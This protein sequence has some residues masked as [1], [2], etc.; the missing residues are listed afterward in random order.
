MLTVDGRYYLYTFSKEEEFE[1]EV[2]KF[3][4]EIFGENTIYINTKKKSIA[5]ELGVSSIPDGFLL[6]LSNP[7][8]IAFYIVE[9]ELSSHDP[10]EIAKQILTFEI[11]YKSHESKGKVYD[12]LIEQIQNDK[13][14]LKIVNEALKKSTVYKDLSTLIYDVVFKQDHRYL[15]II[16]RV[17]ETLKEA[18]NILNV[19]FKIFEFVTFINQKGDKAYAFPNFRDEA[20]QPPE[21]SETWY[22]FCFDDVEEL[23]IDKETF[24]REKNI[25]FFQA[26]VYTKDKE[27]K[28]DG[29][30]FQGYRSR[31]DR[32][33]GGRKNK[34]E[35][36]WGTRRPVKLDNLRV[37]MWVYVVET[38]IDGDTGEKIKNPKL[39]VRGKLREVY[40]ERGKKRE[41]IFPSP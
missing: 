14:M 30:V 23:D 6:D 31:L 5:K 25:G 36:Q 38:N 2:V 20:A 26:F 17:T 41:R 15:I 29:I 35:F 10:K 19:D 28:I 13:E 40:K 1:R 8:D 22:Q 18:L 39:R 4:K 32:D 16:D 3:S 21:E 27:G 7:D 37:G 12:L 24:L 11:T 9:I 34:N 33:L